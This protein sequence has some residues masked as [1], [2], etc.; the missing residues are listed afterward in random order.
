MF[1]GDYGIIN[2]GTSKLM[3]EIE[4][5]DV[6]Q[7]THRLSCRHQI[8]RNGFDYTMPCIVL[9]KTKS[10]KLKIV[11]FGER[12]MALFEKNTGKAE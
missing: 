10:R 11:V 4:K 2:L 3:A 6:S 9:G 1:A 7:A 8:G 12:L 5:Y